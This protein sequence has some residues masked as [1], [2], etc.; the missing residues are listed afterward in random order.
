MVLKAVSNLRHKNKEVDRICLRFL[1]QGMNMNLFY[2]VEKHM[3]GRMVK[4]F[5]QLKFLNK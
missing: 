5:K 4:D 1:F 3:L 2:E